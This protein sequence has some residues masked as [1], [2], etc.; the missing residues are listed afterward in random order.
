MALGILEPKSGGHV[1]GT[2]RLYD[3]QLAPGTE[4]SPPERHRN[5]KHGTGKNS[6][7]LLVPQPSASPND[8]LNWPLWKR[9]LTLLVLGLAGATTAILGPAVAPITKIIVDEFHVSYTE[10]AKWSGWQFW[11]SGIAGLIASAVSRIWGKRSVYLISIL[12]CFAG[13]LWNA[14]ATTPGSFAGARFIQGLGLGAFETIVPSSIGDMYFVHE[15]GKRIA[16]YNLCFL[17]AT[18]FMPVLGGYISMKHGW[19]TQFTIMAVFLGVVSVL[20]FLFVPEHCYNRPAIFDTDT[21]SSENLDELANVQSQGAGSGEQEKK[22]TYIQELALFSGRYSNESLLRCILAPFFLFFYPATIWSFLFQGTFITWGIGVSIILAQV[23]GHPPYNFGPEKLGYMYAAPFVGAVLSYFI[24]GMF[25]D[26]LAKVMSKRNNNIFEPEFRILL[27]IPVAIFALPGIFAFGVAAE[28]HKHWI[29]PSI[30]Y[31]LLTFG[32]VMSCTATYSYVLDAHR[33]ISVEMMVSLLLLKN[34]WAFGSTFFLNNWN[35]RRG[36]KEMFFVIGGIQA[37]VCVLSLGMYVG[38]KLQR[39]AVRRW[40]VLGRM[41]L[42]P[43]TVPEEKRV[44]VE[45]VDTEQAG[46]EGRN[47]I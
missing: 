45:E 18:Y 1:P 8:P 44:V 41:G 7:V 38:G 24:A 13:A 15:R 16:F 39:D 17:G 3:T 2:A 26:Y 5:L 37:A 36:P 11:A 23:F 4:A 27:V 12:L 10:V 47:D 31:G 14:L 21:A 32:V 29:V 28:A 25:S 33:D 46:K 35:A 43:R 34:F 9:D 30:C 20:V 19:R 42:Y 22:K 6:D 40:N